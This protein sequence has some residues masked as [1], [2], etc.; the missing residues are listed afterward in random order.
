MS[1]LH[2]NSTDEEIIRAGLVEILIQVTGFDE[3]PHEEDIPTFTQGLVRF[4]GTFGDR[5]R[6]V[7]VTAPIQELVDLIRSYLQAEKDT[8]D[9]KMHFLAHSDVV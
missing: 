6:C 5:C 9:M 7:E 1:H 4:E 2:Y 3:I 8:R